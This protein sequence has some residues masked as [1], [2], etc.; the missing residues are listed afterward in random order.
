MVVDFDFMTDERVEDE[1]YMP[2]LDRGDIG[3]ARI[4]NSELY[5]RVKEEHDLQKEELDKRLGYAFVPG[6][7]IRASLMHIKKMKSLMTELAE[8]GQELADCEDHDD[9]DD[10]EYGGILN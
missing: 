9:Y 5:K 10:N 8:T 4:A 6:E 7:R 3:L 2:A 1:F